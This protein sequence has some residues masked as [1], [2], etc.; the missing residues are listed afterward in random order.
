MSAQDHVLDSIAGYALDCLSEQEMLHV[1]EHLAGCAACRSELGAYRQVVDNL[2]LATPLHSSPADTKQKL[3]KR[4]AQQTAPA[5]P[6]QHSKKR[7]PAWDWLTRSAPVFAIAGALL[8]VVLFFTILGLAQRIK[9][10]EAVSS[11]FGLVAMEG[12]NNAPGATGMLVLSHDGNLGTLVVDGLTPL[13][14]S[15]QYQLWLI[16]DNSR[17]SGGVFS[18]TPDGYGALTVSSN[19]PLKNYT[20]FGI[21][22]EPAGGSPGPT[23]QKVLDGKLSAGFNPPPAAPPAP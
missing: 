17:E 13:D 9:S 18:V 2:Y 11:D 20:A 15:L 1:S 4:L 6:P 12:T 7:S 22:I 21:T 23:G 3:M 14:N 8:I 5:A 19:Q 10:L 16:H